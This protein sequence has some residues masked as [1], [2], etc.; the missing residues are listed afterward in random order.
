MR[1]I[2]WMIDKSKII[3][4]DPDLRDLGVCQLVEG[5]IQSLE[6]IKFYHFIDMIPAA[7]MAGF[8]FV[9][10]DVTKM[11]PTFNR[12]VRESQLARDKRS[13]NVGMVKAAKIILNDYLWQCGC[14]VYQCPVGVGKQL[15]RDAKLFAKATGWK[16]PTNEDKRD[17][18]SIAHWAFHNKYLGVNHEGIN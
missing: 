8:I 1:G 2:Y 15:K 17:A 9:I 18:Y 5:E 11:K 7:K 14:E 6:S 16:G 13:Q 4:I 10:E 12:K 3:G